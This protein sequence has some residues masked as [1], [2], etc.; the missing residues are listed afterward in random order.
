MT[1]SKPLNTYESAIIETSTDAVDKQA[2]AEDGINALTEIVQIQ[3]VIQS[4]ILSQISKF[5]TKPGFSITP[6]GSILTPADGNHGR[7]LMS[8]KL[9]R[10]M[11]VKLL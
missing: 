4:D 5:Y 2:V 9:L 3:S 8:A 11:G 7:R 10:G 6:D 1:A